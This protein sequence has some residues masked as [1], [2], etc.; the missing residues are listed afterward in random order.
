MIMRIII[1][2]KTILEMYLGEVYNN[3]KFIG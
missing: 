2:I 3:R 1:K